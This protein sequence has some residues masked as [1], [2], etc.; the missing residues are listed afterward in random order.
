MGGSSS[1]P[2]LNAIHVE[3]ELLAIDDDGCVVRLRM[4]NLEKDI[5]VDR[6]IDGRQVG[7][8]E[9]ST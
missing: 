1:E 3:K 7:S 4:L 5:T 6:P 2:Y 8:E 9:L